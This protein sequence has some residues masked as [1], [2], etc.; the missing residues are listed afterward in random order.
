M[1]LGQLGIFRREDGAGSCATS[2]FGGSLL[3]LGWWSLASPSRISGVR[4]VQVGAA[5]GFRSQAVALAPGSELEPVPHCL[6]PSQSLMWGFS[7]SGWAGAR[8]PSAPA[9]SA[10][11]THPRRCGERTGSWCRQGGLRRWPGSEKGH[12][13]ILHERN[14]A[15][16]DTSRCH[17]EE[18][19]IFFMPI[20]ST[21]VPSQLWNESVRAQHG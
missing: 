11:K 13:P 7:V 6:V 10:L 4:G 2:A 20:S 17:S 18:K 16:L 8:P 19:S 12:I 1:G 9:L 3:P 21:S 14:Q 5:R 15:F